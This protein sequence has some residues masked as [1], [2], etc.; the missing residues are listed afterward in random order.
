MR[1]LF[2]SMTR[3]SAGAICFI[4]DLCCFCINFMSGANVSAQVRSTLSRV[5]KLTTTRPMEACQG[6]TIWVTRYGL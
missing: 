4:P 2:D 1:L 3:R 5:P 6:R